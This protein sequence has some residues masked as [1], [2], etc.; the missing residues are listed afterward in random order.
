LAENRFTNAAS[1]AADMTNKQLGGQLGTLSKF[2][3]EEINE[4]LPLKQDKQAFMDLMK[5][6]EAD[7]V[8]DEKVAFLQNNIQSMGKVALTILKTLV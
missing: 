2:S 4:L 6:V 3:D 7:I 1:Q 8:M 5:E